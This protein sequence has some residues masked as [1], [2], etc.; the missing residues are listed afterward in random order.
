MKRKFIFSLMAVSCSF[1]VQAQTADEIIAKY[2]ENTGG[3]AKWEALQGVKFTGKLKFQAMELPMTIIQLK[4]GR[5]TSSIQLQGMDIRDNVYDGNTLWGSNQQTMK[6]EKKDAESTENYKINESKDFPDPFLG[7]QKKG[8]KAEFVGKETID[9][10]EAFKIKL[11][12]K[13]TKVDGKENENVSFYYFDTENYV[14]ILQETEVKAGPSKGMVTQIK[15]S[16]YQDA[17]GLLFPFTM[18]LGAKGQP[19]GQTLVIT[20]IEINPKVDAAAFAF[21][22][23]KPAEKK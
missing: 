23:E 20:A 3:L 17:G 8:Y 15:P 9:G 18:A 10:T 22:V 16:D 5:T 6:A 13:P 7:Y 11:T 12:K 1:F 4:D 14:P 21:P 19:G 2:F